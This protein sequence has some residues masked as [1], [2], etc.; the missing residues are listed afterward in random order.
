MNKKHTIQHLLKINYIKTENYNMME[1]HEK[2]KMRQIP[3]LCR[4]VT[5][6]PAGSAF[7]KCKQLSTTA[8]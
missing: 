5:K 7:L 4:P 3:R 1:M 6:R 8:T 2:P